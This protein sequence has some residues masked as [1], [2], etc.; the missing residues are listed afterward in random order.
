M[1]VNS[2]AQAVV[3]S[4]EQHPERVA[5]KI[6]DE[7]LTYGDLI[8]KSAQVADTLKKQGAN[9]EA[10]GVVGQRHMASYV[11]VLGA[12]LAGCY[13][14]PINPKLSKE[15]IIS[16]INDSNIKLL[17]GD[18]D[19]FSKINQ[20]LDDSSCK[21]I[22]KK[23]IPFELAPE[24]SDWLDKKCI[25]SESFEIDFSNISKGDLAYV[26][27]TSGSTG[28]PK[29]VQVTNAN[30]LSYLSA[31]SLLWKLP[32]HFK[33]SQ[34]HD[35]SFDPS[36][37]DIFYTWSNG[38]VL[39]IVP[40]VDMLLPVDFI[41]NEKIDIWSSVPSIG[42]FMLKMGVLEKNIFPNLKII[43]FA[44][45]ALSK[46]IADAWRVA[47]PNST[48][49]N[50]Y[51]PTEATIDV[52]S[53]CYSKKDKSASYNNNVIPIGK[54]MPG[55]KVSIIDNES[56]QV[57]KGDIGEIV[58]KGPQI[59]NG[60]LNDQ[61]KTDSVFVTFD[62]DLSNETWYK[63]GDL[64]FYNHDGNLECTGRKDNQIKLGG[65]RV[66]IGE[67][68]A[69]LSK[70]TLLQDVVVVGIKDDN[71]TTIG[72][73]AFTM[74]EINKEEQIRIRQKS[75]QHLERVFF[76]K[77]I[78]TIDEFPRSPSGKIDRNILSLKAQSL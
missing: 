65:R 24:G 50:H 20:S 18:V 78:I 69:E 37:S 77:K 17:V 40:E 25:D 73:V 26:M 12:L 49:E 23:I 35:L 21:I 71:Q 48:V 54:P 14:V 7:V 42:T 1:K 59:S 76:P 33:M 29:G 34:F 16:I 61:K 9:K 51:G 38:G 11:G 62:W 63:S 60:Y 10:I 15:K 56:N 39:C 74:N 22:V 55:M 53:F 46:K 43:R 75:V 27:Y 72:C 67:I 28:N 44:G 66:E 36:V 70:F 6:K 45:E 31:I 32:V 19:N 52:A 2:L 57:K 41:I 5:I 4:A 64:G 58:Y 68:E 13:Y 47:A 30:V 3:E 8:Q